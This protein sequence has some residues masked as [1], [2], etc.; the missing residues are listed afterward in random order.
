V[1]IFSRVTVERMRIRTSDSYLASFTSASFFSQSKKVSDAEE[2]PTPD[3]GCSGGAPARPRPLT[4]CSLRVVP[5]RTLRN[6]SVLTIRRAYYSTKPPEHGASKDSSRIATCGYY[7]YLSSTVTPS[8]LPSQEALS[9][10]HPPSP[11]PLRPL[12]SFSFPYCLLFT[13]VLW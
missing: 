3:P 13:C 11:P 12:S 1:Q 5:R 7:Y 8:T 6:K 10:S 2:E 9:P 4:D